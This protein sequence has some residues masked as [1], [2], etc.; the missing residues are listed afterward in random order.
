[1]HASAVAF[2]GR[3]VLLTGPSGSGKSTLALSLISI[4]GI[5]VADDQVVLEPRSGELWLSAPEP[6]RGQIEARG[7][8]ILQTP[9][10][11]ASAALVV[12]MSDTETERLPEWG[13]CEIAGVTL[14]RVR[15]VESPAFAAML[16]V[17]LLEGPQE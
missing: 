10:V 12:D 3:A 14:P 7:F 1:M 11:E 2:G 5:L 15:K 17:Y 4:G 13:S 8:G 16:R 9:R 6:L